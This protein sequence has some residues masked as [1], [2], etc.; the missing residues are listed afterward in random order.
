MANMKQV[1]PN[2]IE[3]GE[4]SS[5]TKQLEEG[6]ILIVE[7]GTALVMVKQL[8]IL[9]VSDH[10]ISMEVFIEL[11]SEAASLSSNISRYGLCPTFLKETPL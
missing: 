4:A 6:G 9:S 8:C 3:S 10:T 5:P 7:T 11:L 1:T 2:N